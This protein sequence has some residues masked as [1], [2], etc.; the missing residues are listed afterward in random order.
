MARC[1][2]PAVRF[3]CTN[4][5]VSLRWEGQECSTFDLPTESEHLP[6]EGPNVLHDILGDHVRPD[7]VVGRVGNHG[8]NNLWQTV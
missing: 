2:I 4:H 1:L 5:K 8:N 3:R 7:D 6:L